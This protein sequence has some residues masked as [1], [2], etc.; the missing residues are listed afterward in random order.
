MSESYLSGR[1]RSLKVGIT[2][3]TEHKNVLTVVGGVGIGTDDTQLRDLYVVGNAGIAGVLTAT[4]YY[5]DGQN[6]SNTGA[7]LNAAS[8]TQRLVVT[9]LTS[10]TMTSAATDGGLTYNAVG[11]TL[12]AANLIVAGI[13]TVNG[14]LD[15]N[16]TIDIDGQVDVDELV[17]AGVTTFQDHIYLG[18]SDK[19]YFGAGKDLT[20]YS[21]GTV[22]RIQGKEGEDGIVLTG[23]AGVDLYFDNS[24][25][26]RTVGTGVSIINGISTSATLHG[27]ENF[28]IDPHPS[29]VGATSGNVRIKG[30]LYVDGT[31]FIVDSDRISLGDFVVGIATTVA[32]EA[33]TDGAGIGIGSEGHEKTFKYEYN[34]GTNPSLKSSE[35]LNVASGKGYQINQ[36]SVLSS[37]TLGA[38][39]VNSSLTNL[40]TL[41]SAA[42]S[43]GLDVGGQADLDEVVI[44]GVTTFN[45]AN[46]YVD[47][48]VGTAIT[49]HAGNI[50]SVGVITAGR[51]VGDGSGLANLPGINTEASSVFTDITVAG[52]ANIIGVTTSGAF[53]GDGSGLTGIGSHGDNITAKQLWIAGVSTIAGNVTLAGSLNQINVTGIATFNGAIDSN[54]GINIVGGATIDQISATGVT[55]FTSS[56]D[57]NGGID[58]DGQADLDEVVIAGVTTTNALLDVNN[59]LDVAGGAVLDQISA[60]GIS[61]YAGL[62]DVN[63][64][65]DVVGGANIDQLNVTGVSTHV[66]ISTFQSNVFVGSGITM[67]ANLGIISAIAFYGDGKNLTSLISGK[68][69][70]I[71]IEDEGSTVGTAGSVGNINFVSSNLTA[72]ASG[73]GATI[74]LA[75]D[76]AF[77][78]GNYTGVVTATKF[79]GDGSE[80]T[81]IAAGMGTALGTE[82]PLHLAFKTPRTFTIGAGRSVTIESDDT[83][84]NIAYTCA[85]DIFVGT[86]A[87]FAVGSGT[88]F[89][90][91]VLAIF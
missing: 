2:S 67:S 6:L 37:T 69:A 63:A 1:Q 54:A 19:A 9:S 16:G 48:A 38:S 35:N 55:T 86:A 88:T 15:V 29:G 64:R 91:N 22:G 40:G 33:L 60:T 27:P 31:E 78:G 65:L 70:G 14:S 39:V 5:G 61:T 49:I 83:S 58:V 59:R 81:G 51:F 44:A 79:K 34:S 52:G 85:A 28:I 76:V 87:T 53:V 80:L 66:G 71:T 12:N 62:V 36:T 32:T 43:G 90:T 7:D 74:T 24:I 13:A 30:N 68:V 21:D 89:V 11:D 73:T 3:H 56:I 18:D 41:T 42:I 4:S 20:I 17:V 57:A 23:D 47:T 46:I 26:L 72:T 45:Q 84:G 77:I 75:P 82:S 10:G 25:K 8:G 50:Q